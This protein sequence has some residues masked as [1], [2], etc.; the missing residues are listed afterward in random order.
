MRRTEASHLHQGVRK[1][2]NR[3]PWLPRF[4]GGYD[5]IAESPE[6]NFSIRAPMLLF[7]PNLELVAQALLFNRSGVPL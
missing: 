1:A 2:L 3:T 5:S 6:S 7:L 4:R